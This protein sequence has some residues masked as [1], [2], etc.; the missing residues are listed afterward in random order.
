MVL[1]FAVPVVAKAKKNK[2]GKKR[3]H[4]MGNQAEQ[5]KLKLEE[6]LEGLTDKDKNTL[7][8]WKEL[9]QTT[10]PFI[11]PVRRLMRPGEAPDNAYVEQQDLLIKQQF[12]E[13]EK[14]HKQILEYEKMI[15]EQNHLISALREKHKTLVL[16]CQASGVK[17]S[18]DLL[19][20]CAPR[21]GSS[22]QHLVP[23]PSSQSSLMSTHASNPVLQPPARL[24]PH[25]PTPSSTTSLAPASPANIFSPPMSQP[26]YPNISPTNRT[27]PP[28]PP[29]S[30]MP[31]PLIR[32]LHPSVSM[33]SLSNIDQSQKTTTS[34][35]SQLNPAHL[36][37]TGP[38]NNRFLPVNQ[39]QMLMGGGT[40]TGHAQNR[41]DMGPMSDQVPTSRQ[42][43]FARKGAHNSP[44]L[45]EDISFSPLTSSELKE[46]EPHP[47][48]YLPHPLVSFNEDLDS[49]LNLSMLSGNG[50]GYGVGVKEED[51]SQGSLQIDLRYVS[52]SSCHLR[53]AL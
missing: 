5:K 53:L 31:P 45:I 16:E 20:N 27:P 41:I 11:H 17:L 32:S 48:V 37:G 30:H 46:F 8:R 50:A 3:K 33:D 25:P 43:S 28:G 18:S 26:P 24:P 47:G 36:V 35:Y 14:Q 40:H 10:R 34:S 38:H 52:Y 22:C 13:I 9:Q 2:T 21:N 49:I 23:V 6:D 4:L 1:P 12:S 7:S 42:Q 51:L 15:K 19:D 39:S 29:P 44:M